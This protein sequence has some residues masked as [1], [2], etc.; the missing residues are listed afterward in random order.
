VIAWI[1]EHWRI[2]VYSI[3]A[4]LAILGIKHALRR[5]SSLVDW[6]H[7]REA[8]EW[9]FIPGSDNEVM[10]RDPNTNQPVVVELPQGVSAQAVVGVGIT[11]QGR[12]VVEATHEPVDRRSIL[13]GD[14]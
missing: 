9:S 13:R 4:I 10:V 11:S 6:V 14:S 5:L 1:K 3:L 8:R 7:P 2:L 12:Y